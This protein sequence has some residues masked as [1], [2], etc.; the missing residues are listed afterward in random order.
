MMLF[1]GYFSRLELLRSVGY[2]FPH[3]GRSFSFN[4]ADLTQFFREVQRAEYFDSILARL[5]IEDLEKMTMQ[6]EGQMKEIVIGKKYDCWRH[7]VFVGYYTWTGLA[8]LMISM[9]FTHVVILLKVVVV[10]VLVV[11]VVVVVAVVVVVLYGCVDIFL[12][13]SLVYTHMSS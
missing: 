1:S 9:F 12:P 2:I 10:A 3:P 13:D 11:V 6:F 4:L 8:L 5:S 7:K